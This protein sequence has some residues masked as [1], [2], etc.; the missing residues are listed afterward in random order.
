MCLISASLVLI[1]DLLRAHTHAPVW[2]LLKPLD[3]LFC[4][5]CSRR[6]SH[7]R[8]WRRLGRDWRAGARASAW[9]KSCHSQ[10]H[11][12][13][14]HLHLVLSLP[15]GARSRL[16][17]LLWLVSVPPDDPPPT[18]YIFKKLAWIPS[19]WLLFTHHCLFKLAFHSHILLS[20]TTPAPQPRCILQQV[21]PVEWEGCPSSA[22]ALV[23]KCSSHARG[24]P[25]SGQTVPSFSCFL[26]CS[27]KHW[28]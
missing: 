7:L 11:H 22:P 2:W 28:G 26:F 25:A 24:E 6:K 8:V 1:R 17:K 5:S 12:H 23:P 20:P 3:D 10:D 16:C 15:L 21:P 9:A 19:G 13:H 27:A 14:L 4:R 18:V